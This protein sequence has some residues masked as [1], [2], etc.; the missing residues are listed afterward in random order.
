MKELQT[1][2]RV[3]DKLTPKIMTSPL[4]IVAEV[5]FVIGAIFALLSLFRLIDPGHRAEIMQGIVSQ[6]VSDP[7]AITTWFYI[8]VIGK[9]LFALYALTFSIG[10]AIAMITS[11]NCKG[12][13]CKIKGLGFLSAM[14]KAAIWIW[15]A[16]LGI[17]GV[18]FV[19]RIVV[20]AVVLIQEVV[21]FVFPLAAVVVGELVMALMVFGV[22]T[23]LIF[24][25][26]EL[27]DLATHLRYMLYTERL[28]SHIE[29]VSYVALFA[30]AVFCGYLVY[31]FIY[32][33]IA[34]VTFSCL[35]VASLLTGICIA[36]LKNRVEW[37]HFLNYE[38]DKNT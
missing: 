8:T 29:P 23:L 17:A 38:R 5:F 1:T 34:I 30:L 19:Y 13:P 2:K 21:D 35:T 12:N 25:W 14:N 3:E 7:E 16:L 27:A 32:D 22:T 15:V 9:A 4:L 6:N 26:K 33:P 11:A 10:L 37:M 28:D 31:Y 24:L 36:V 18:V 20:Y